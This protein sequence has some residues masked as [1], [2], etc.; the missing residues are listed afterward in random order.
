MP[1]NID[2][3]A[4]CLPQNQT[5]A[6]FLR[7]HAKSG[8]CRGRMVDPFHTEARHRRFRHTFDLGHADSAYERQPVH[9]VAELRSVHPFPQGRQSCQT[10][11]KPM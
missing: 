1:G 2:S 8:E 6:G 3:R 10:T 4:P 5:K 11:Q 9:P 7:L